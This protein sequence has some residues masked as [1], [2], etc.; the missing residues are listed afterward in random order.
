[1]KPSRAEARAANCFDIKV[2]CAGGAA[3]L[4]L[5]AERAAGN[6]S[7]QGVSG[8]LI[9]IPSVAERIGKRISMSSPGRERGE[10]FVPEGFADLIAYHLR[11]AQDASFQAIRQRAGKS[12]LK[13]GWYATLTI[14]SDNPGLTPTELSLL[15]GRDRSTLSSTLKAL[16]ARGFIARRHTPGDQRS[17]SVRLTAAGEAMLKKLRVIA[18][19]HD[20]RL[21]AIVGKDKPVLIA[22]LRRIAETLGQPVALTRRQSKPAVPARARRKSARARAA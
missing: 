22:V 9:R 7:R 8:K 13:P 21:D 15:C 3:L 12:D 6:R 20:A 2:T 19:I 5:A 10:S 11:L 16:S 1:M 18:R 14:L 4:S 17:Y